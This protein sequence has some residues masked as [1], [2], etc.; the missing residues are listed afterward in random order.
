MVFSDVHIL[1]MIIDHMIPSSLMNSLVPLL[2]RCPIM[3]I[4]KAK[5]EKDLKNEGLDASKISDIWRSSVMFYPDKRLHD[6]D[7]SSVLYH[8]FVSWSTIRIEK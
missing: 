3:W 1:S 7:P 4:V 5:L 8:P 2:D 6:V